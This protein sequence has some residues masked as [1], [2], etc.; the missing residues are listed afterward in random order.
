MKIDVPQK[1]QPLPVYS[2]IRLSNPAFSSSSTAVVP[3]ILAPT[4]DAHVYEQVHQQFRAV[5]G[6]V[7]MGPVFK[8]ADQSQVAF[9]GPDRPAQ[10]SLTSRNLLSA[11][12][13]LVL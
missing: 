8:Q 13:S 6:A 10:F 11:A 1:R 7:G 5:E 12:E 3:S 2:Q 9:F 4:F